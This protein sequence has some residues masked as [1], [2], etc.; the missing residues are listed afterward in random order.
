MI[1]I[2]LIFWSVAFVLTVL[3]IM[4]HKTDALGIIL[5]VIICFIEMFGITYN[6]GKLLIK[7]GNNDDTKQ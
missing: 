1:L 7:K 3:N 6:Y 4:F 2:N 5:T